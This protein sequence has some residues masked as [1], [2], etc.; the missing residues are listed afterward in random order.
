MNR[1]YTD[2][3]ERQSVMW[4]FAYLART[5]VL[6]FVSQIVAKMYVEQA[7]RGKSVKTC[8]EA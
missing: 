8:A 2:A 3:A 1:G 7:A 5:L 4:L 6:I